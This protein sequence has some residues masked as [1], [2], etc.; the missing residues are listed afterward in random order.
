[1]MFDWAKI[2]A[3]K[4]GPSLITFYEGPPD[5]LTLRDLYF[6]QLKLNPCV[7]CVSLQVS[8]SYVFCFSDSWSLC[9]LSDGQ[10]LCQ[11]FNIIL[12]APKNKKLF[13]RVW[14]K[15]LLSFAFIRFGQALIKSVWH[16]SVPLCFVQLC[17]KAVILEDSGLILV[18]HHP[19]A[20]RRQVNCQMKKQLTLIKQI[21]WVKTK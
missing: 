13:S 14:W 20:L 5:L 21:A 11:T 8:V 18:W 1:M 17:S 16:S 7:H 15:G 12:E 4:N 10:W 3:H 2:I 6:P 19:C 9:K